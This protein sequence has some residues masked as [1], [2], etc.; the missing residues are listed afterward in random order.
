MKKIAQSSCLLVCFFFS[1]F[2][3]TY[4]QDMDNRKM[5]RILSKE[6]QKVEGDLGNWQ[7]IYGNRG[8][9]IIT[10]ANANRMRIMTPVI[11]LKDIK[12]KEYQTLLEA[13]FD[14]ALD[15]KYCIY[16]QYLMTVF[17]H[18][19]KELSEEQ[20]IDALR[21]VVTLAYNYGTSYTSTDLVFGGG[22]EAE[23]EKE[24]K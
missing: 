24:D 20:F 22:Q 12:K 9:Y 1:L 6:A 11:E 13:N 16:E 14:R 7:V 17:T 15:A 23:E 2:S 21:Q 3:L 5:S 18:P 19:L 4:S 8:V 10:D